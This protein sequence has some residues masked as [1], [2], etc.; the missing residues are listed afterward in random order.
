MVPG[1][2]RDV[3]LL[4]SNEGGGEVAKVKNKNSRRLKK[5]SWVEK[6]ILKT[7]IELF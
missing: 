5:M 3:Y 2:F 1:I 7:E 4:I 6:S